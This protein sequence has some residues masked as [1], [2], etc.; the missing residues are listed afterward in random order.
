MLP[1]VVLLPLYADVDCESARLLTWPLS[2]QIYSF[3][4]ILTIATAGRIEAR[5]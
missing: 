4:L 5:I 2:I 1:R 3:I